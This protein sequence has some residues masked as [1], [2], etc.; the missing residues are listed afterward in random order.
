MSYVLCLM[1]YV[2]KDDLAIIPLYP[3]VSIC[4]WGILVASIPASAE[5]CWQPSLNLMNNQQLALVNISNKKTLSSQ[6]CF[7]HNSL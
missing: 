6:R 1:S 7:L 5:V 2:I 3:P 4:C